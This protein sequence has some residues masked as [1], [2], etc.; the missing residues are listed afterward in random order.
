M[1]SDP[2]SLELF[3]VGAEDG[4]LWHRSVVGDTWSEWK[5]LG[6]N[7]NTAPTAISLA[8]K[9]VTAFCV[10]AEMRCLIGLSREVFGVIGSLLL[11]PSP[12]LYNRKNVR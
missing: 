3:A 8:S 4:G 1:V 6:G 12:L 2:N 5:S 7:C 10:D 9:D 11:E